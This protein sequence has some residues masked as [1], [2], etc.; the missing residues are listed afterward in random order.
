MIILASYLTLL[1]AALTA[2]RADLWRTTTVAV[3]MIRPLQ[4][5]NKHYSEFDDIN[6][7]R[8]TS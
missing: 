7:T 2:C 4:A 3:D 5:P 1:A 6:S 8:A